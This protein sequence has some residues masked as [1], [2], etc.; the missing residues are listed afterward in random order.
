MG[1]ILFC[2]IDYFNLTFGLL[3]DVILAIRSLVH[4]NYILQINTNNTKLC[5]KVSGILLSHIHD[6]YTE[7]KLTF[8]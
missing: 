2:F 8:S 3:K 6:E 5:H 4:A 7:I 1:K